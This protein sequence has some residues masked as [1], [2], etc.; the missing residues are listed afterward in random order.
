MWLKAALKVQNQCSNGKEIINDVSTRLKTSQYLTR[1]QVL[2]TVK[3]KC[4]GTT[5]LT[6]DDMPVIGGDIRLENSINKVKYEQ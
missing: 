2:E 5:N 6:I 3:Q 1:Q 4:K